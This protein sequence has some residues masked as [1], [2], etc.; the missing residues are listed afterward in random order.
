MTNSYRTIRRGA[1]AVSLLSISA[2]AP[3]AM[4]EDG[5]FTFRFAYDQSRL[6]TDAEARQVYQDLVLSAHQACKMKAPSA[7]RQVET[8]C[9]ANLIDSVISN[10]GD[11]RL[12]RIQQATPASVSAIQTAIR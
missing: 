12:V 5:N 11:S 4:A 9:Q 2:A 1:L 8:N 10:I 3:V 7:Q 6:Q